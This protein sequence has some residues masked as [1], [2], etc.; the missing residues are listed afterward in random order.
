VDATPID[1]TPIDGAVDADATVDATPIDATPIDAGDSSVALGA[2]C[3]AAPVLAVG[4][5]AADLS[6]GSNDYA[7]YTGTCLD[8]NQA[9]LD[10]AGND[11]SFTVDVPAGQYLEV[12]VQSSFTGFRMVLTDSCA[13]VVT[14][15][16]RQHQAQ[17]GWVNTTASTQSITVV[18][19]ATTGG[20]TVDFTVALSD[21]AASRLPGDTCQNAIRLSGA[22]SYVITDRT[23]DYHNLYSDYMSAG[24]GQSPQTAEGPD[25]VYVTELAAGEALQGINRG[26]SLTNAR[27]VWATDCA[28][29]ATTCTDFGF[30][31]GGERNTS[32]VARDYYIIIEGRDSSDVGQADITI[33]I[34]P[35]L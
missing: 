34:L 14:S 15:C 27:I 21:P 7:S 5:Y 1:A 11:G 25:R 24:C 30:A 3:G 29:L 12:D 16:Q 26:G 13:N 6:G 32:G 33:N 20:G 23:D 2:T 18:F 17:V 19:D 31:P 10:L 9:S 22:I 35:P 28:D 4:T 8:F